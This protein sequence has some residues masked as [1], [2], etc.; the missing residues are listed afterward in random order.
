[1]NYKIITLIALVATLFTTTSCLKDENET[2]V[3][4]YDD[5]A[6]TSFTL[7]TLNQV[8]DTIGKSGK[9]ST[10]TAMYKGSQYKFYIDHTNAKIYNTDSLPY[11]TKANAILAS[12]STKNGGIIAIKSLTGETFKRYDNKDSIDFSKDRQ[13]YVYANSVKAYRIYTVTVNIKKQ[14][15]SKFTWT[16]LT[17][18]PTFATLSATKAVGTTDKVF[19]AGVNGA[20]TTLYATAS[21]DGSQWATSSHTFS[22][23]AY[24]NLVAQ[25]N[26]LFILDDDK[27]QSS[28]DGNNWTVMSQDNTF[29]S[30]FAS[31]LALYV[32]TTDGKI[33]MST[34][35]GITWTDE[36]LAN[37]ATDLPTSNI[38]SGLFTTL[39]G[40][41]LSRLL[42]VGINANNSVSEWTRLVNTADTNINYHWT[43][44][45]AASPYPL[46]AYKALTVVSYNNQP[47]ALGLT[48]KNE[49]ATLLISGDQGITW[50]NNKAYTIPTASTTA[51][52]LAA[53]VDKD[54]HLWVISGSKVWKGFFK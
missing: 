32:I 2:K 21:T 53:A 33:K 24:K 3:V 38:S 27:V 34:D 1:M 43:T 46:P 15:T 47:L 36:T 42:L 6:I 19:V 49:I 39:S 7:G 48:T 40:N 50:K 14:K 17:D 26:T 11:G 23:S 5:T 20:T 31:P 44:I 4:T 54:N 16:S 29:A 51:N 10:Y 37:D 45:E 18:N 25:G 22:A 13:L 35:K 28:T 52:T 41:N 9:D 8:R 30:L 12:I